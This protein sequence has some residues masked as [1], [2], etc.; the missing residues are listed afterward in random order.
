MT[1]RTLAAAILVLITGCDPS[2]PAGV[3][4][5][6]AEALQPIVGGSLDSGDP[7][8]VAVVARRARCGESGA[9]LTCSGVLVAPRVVLTAAHCVR[10]AGG[11]GGFEVFFGP[12]LGGVEGTFVLAG[13]ALVHP[14]WDGAS[15]DFDLGLLRLAEPAPVPALA[16]PPAAAGDLLVGQSLRAVGFGATAS[17]K[18][19]DGDKREGTLLV[20]AVSASMFS[21]GP[22]PAMSCRGDSGGPVLV[23]TEGGESLAGITSGGD[24]ACAKDARQ[25][26]VDVAWDTFILPYVAAKDGAPPTGTVPKTALCEQPC[27]VDADCPAWLA[28]LEGDGGEGRCQLPGGV[29]ADLGASCGEDADC[30]DGQWC[31][32]LSPGGPEA[33]QCAT[34]CGA[35][36][37]DPSPGD[38]GGCSIHRPGSAPRLP[39]LVA[40]LAVGLHLARRRKKT[41][42]RRTK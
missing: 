22:G 37:P 39:W 2:G 24:A 10:G 15:A 36:A 27:S 13:D 25:A 9:A 29:N 16:A 30:G 26:R 35:A 6:P 34:P 3:D 38:V 12:S 31:Q 23:A 1:P 17:E 41:R 20:T 14:S 33:C 21:A 7:A 11:Y 5:D 19:T 42:P 28:C 4:H 8:V 32:R 18:G 40:A